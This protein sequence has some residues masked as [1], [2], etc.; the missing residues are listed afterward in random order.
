MNLAS[1][2]GLYLYDPQQLAPSAGPRVPGGGQRL[3]QVNAA[4]PA[5]ETTLI[6]PG[7]HIMLAEA[8][9]AVAAQ[10]ILRH[11]LHPDIPELPPRDPHGR[12][13][14]IVKAD[15]Q[16]AESDLGRQTGE[17]GGEGMLGG[18]QLGFAGDR[19]CAVGG[20]GSRGLDLARLGL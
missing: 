12:L 2:L 14:G 19:E 7:L 8:L 15:V 18:G 20:R 3:D 10:V 5:L 6:H 4:L 13:S 16:I 9:D 17:E 1:L 11:E